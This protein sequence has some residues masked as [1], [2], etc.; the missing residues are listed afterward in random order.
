MKGQLAFEAIT[1]VSDSLITE[2]AELLGLLRR[3]PTP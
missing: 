3:T 1:N 2:S